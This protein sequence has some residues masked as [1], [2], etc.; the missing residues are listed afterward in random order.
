MT[1]TDEVSLHRS[2]AAAEIVSLAVD[3]SHDME[4]DTS[5]D[6]E[7]VEEFEE[8]ELF[9]ISDEDNANNS[10]QSDSDEDFF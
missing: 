7:D 9:E 6:Y 10:V 4:H 8:E 1:E 5:K 2:D 3:S